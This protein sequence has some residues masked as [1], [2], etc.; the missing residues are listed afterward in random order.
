MD[1]TNKFDDNLR[2]NMLKIQM[3]ALRSQD[4]QF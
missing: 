3:A 1:L 4:N 2:K